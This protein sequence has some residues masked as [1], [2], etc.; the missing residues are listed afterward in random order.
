MSSPS[1]QVALLGGSFD[2]VHLGHVALAQAALHQLPIDALW[3]LPAG[4]AWQKDR[5]LSPA[6]HRLA[7]LE[8]TVGRDPRQRIETCEL[9]RTGPT[10]TIDTLHELIKRYPG[11]VWHLLLGWD[12]F[13]NLPTWKQWTD[14]VSRVRLAVVPR[15]RPVAALPPELQ[16]LPVQQLL[17]APWEVSS[18]AIRADVGQG[19]VIL[20]R[21]SAPVARYIDEHGLYLTR[22]PSQELNGHP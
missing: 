8:L 16:A 5:A 11:V 4:L 12:Q 21:V 7:M 22:P 15:T 18:T 2:P 6:P 20:D 19:R 1:R 9:E 10:Y 3:W 17:M 14:V 13:L